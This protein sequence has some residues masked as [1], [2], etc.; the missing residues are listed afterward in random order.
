MMKFN[1]SQ[2]FSYSS[3]GLS[4]GFIGLPLY[5]YLP[6]FYAEEFS[7]SLTYLSALFF[8]TRLVDTVQDPLIG[9]VSDR[10]TLNSIKRST[11]IAL[12]YPFL[13]LSFLGLL[14]PVSAVPIGISL[15]FF[16][17]TTYTL[18]SVIAINFNTLSAEYAKDY[19]QQTILV[20]SRE[21][22][23][24]IGI[25]LGSIIPS[26]LLNHFS[27]ITAH[28]MTW[29][30]FVAVS[31]FGLFFFLKNPL[32]ILYAQTV[33]ENVW[34][35]LFN[36]SKDKRFLWLAGVFLCSTTAAALPAT[37]VLFYIK[38]V[39]HAEAYFGIFLAIY[40]LCALLGIPVWYKISAAY[41]KRSAWISA[42]AFTIIGFVWATFLG[43]DDL[44]AYGIICVITGFC[45]GADLIM[46]TSML[47]DGISLKTNK[48]KYYGAWTMISKLSITVA[49]SLGLFVLGILGYDP[50][51]GMQSESIYVSIAYAFI[52]CVIKSVALGILF[53]KKDIERL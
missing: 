36:L 44:I 41:T 22:L 3:L 5:V 34:E 9:W 28:Q 7:L 20:S 50:G 15:G 16:L 12:S 45:L 29:G 42:M 33:S 11:I 26:L 30:I 27:I 24:L 46:P 6:K 52:P 51:A 2:V 37:L 39:L 35:A 40:F 4:L 17:I 23:T 49:G 25:A 10:L 32:P 53:I 31:G 18:Y 38:D 21:G 48:A 43:S 19:N 1:Q 13:C 47:A 8:I 14:F